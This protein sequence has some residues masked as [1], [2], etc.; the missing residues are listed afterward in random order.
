MESECRQLAVAVRK[1]FREGA[2]A[3]VLSSGGWE[4][5]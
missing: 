3:L 1:H 5:G 2:C 4:K